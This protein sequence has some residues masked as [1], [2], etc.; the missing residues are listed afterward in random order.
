MFFRRIILLAAPARA[1]TEKY[2]AIFLMIAALS[3]MLLSN[4]YSERMTGL[5]SAAL[6]TFAPVLSVISEPVRAARNVAD[7]M[8]DIAAVRAQNEQLRGENEKL[9][10]WYNL[11]L[12][13]QSE[14]RSL[15]DLLNM[16]QDAEINY[17]T[18]RVIADSGSAYV[19]SVM[20]EI[21]QN[22]QGSRQNTSAVKR[23]MAVLSGQGLVGRVID[24]DA[25]NHYARILLVTDMSSRIPVLLENSRQR[26][27]VAGDNSAALALDHV[28]DQTPVEIG[29]RVI[30]SGYDGVFPA[31]LPVGRV[32]KMADKN[33][34]AMP[35]IEPLSDLDRLDIVRLVDYGTI[36]NGLAVAPSAVVP[37]GTKP[38][39][40]EGA[41][42]KGKPGHY[43]AKS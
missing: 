2:L 16:K 19:H 12:R 35:V 25:S 8:H 39:P 6:T 13:M 14:N 32:T 21:P 17:V 24:L 4:S 28:P 37:P 22:F 10:D 7:N 40:I 38:A 18:A 34:D 43:K 23:G 1:L 9:R 41:K 5:R 15:K 33:S 36:E 11:A 27:V 26:A 31:G 42:H 29:E 20:V 3:T 30:T